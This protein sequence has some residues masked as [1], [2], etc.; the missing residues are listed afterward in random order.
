MR[1]FMSPLGSICAASAAA[2]LLPRLAAV[3]ELRGAL[4]AIL[5]ALLACVAA[6]AYLQPKSDRCR[7]RATAA[8]IE[9]FEAA[10]DETAH[11]LAVSASELHR[12]QH[13]ARE[14]A[15]ELEVSRRAAGALVELERRRAALLAWDERDGSDSRVVAKADMS[16]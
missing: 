11:A 12:A 5:S 16:A 2:L 14:H 3:P 6:Q 9:L 1:A 13:A 10:A 7:R 15:R 4:V 8:V